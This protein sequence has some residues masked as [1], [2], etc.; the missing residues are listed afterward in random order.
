MSDIDL[1]RIKRGD[2]VRLIAGRYEGRT[3]VAAR[4]LNEGAQKESDVLV[5]VRFHGGTQDYCPMTHLEKVTGPV[6]GD[7]L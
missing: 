1:K 2:E 4:I 6:R 3:G 5:L 7:N